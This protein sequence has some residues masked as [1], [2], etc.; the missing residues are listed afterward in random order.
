MLDL[1][2]QELRVI[3]INKL[4]LKKNGTSNKIIVQQLVGI[5]P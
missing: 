2:I 4:N 3:S 1:S 5:D